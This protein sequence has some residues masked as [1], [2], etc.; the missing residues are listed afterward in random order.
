MN[1]ATYDRTAETSANTFQNVAEL[2]GRVLLVSLF[3]LS[4]LGKIGAYSA[5]AGY[6]ASVGVPGALLPLVI[7]IEV[8]GAAAIIAGWNTRIVAFLLAGFSLVSALLFHNDFANQ[9]QMIMFLK[10]VSIAG[11]FLLL[12]AHGAGPLSLDRRAAK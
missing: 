5:T 4:G 2:G 11:G 12:V 7:A 3:L 9:I 8:L 10:N 1:T 6:M